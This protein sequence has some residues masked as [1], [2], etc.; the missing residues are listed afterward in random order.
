MAHKLDPNPSVI[1]YAVVYPWAYLF[2]DT[3]FETVIRLEFRPLYSWFI[4]L[5]SRDWG[6][7]GTRFEM[8]GR[9]GPKIGNSNDSLGRDF[10]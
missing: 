8:T 10:L 5:S 4:N 9:K 6:I 1:L 2:V 3:L 7:V